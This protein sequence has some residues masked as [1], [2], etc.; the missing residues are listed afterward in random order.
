MRIHRI[1]GIAFS[2]Y[3]LETPDAL[4]L[5]DTGFC[6]FESLVL[7]KIRAIGRRADELGLVLITHPHLDHMGGVAALSRHADFDVVAHPRAA[8]VLAAGGKAFS[9]SR[10]GW[11]RAVE[12]LATTAFPFMRLPAVTPTIEPEDGARLDDHGLAATVL[13]TPGHTDSCLTLVVDGGATFVGDLIIG[14]GHMSTEVAPP[15]MAVDAGKAQASIRK[16]LAAGA[17]R[18]LPAHGREF[19]ATDAAA[20]LERAS[21]RTV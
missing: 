16:V 14:A 1:Q 5:V 15:A 3:L 7:R 11:T 4:F 21:R 6:W 18:M 19:T 20:A 8:P 12:L 10:G 2:S 9:P 17:R 13:H